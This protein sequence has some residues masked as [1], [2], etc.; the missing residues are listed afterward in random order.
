M[1]A[2]H[3]Q[4]PPMWR[5]RIVSFWEK[6]RSPRQASLSVL[7]MVGLWRLLTAH[8]LDL[9]PVRPRHRTR[10]NSTGVHWPISGCDGAEHAPAGIAPRGAKKADA[11]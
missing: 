4:L 8:T 5:M 1:G 3:R 11:Q 7:R 9:T 6:S 2:G 10:S